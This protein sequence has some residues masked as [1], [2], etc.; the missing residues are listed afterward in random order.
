MNIYSN[1]DKVVMEDI[2][3]LRSISDS[4]LFTIAVGVVWIELFKDF[5]YFYLFPRIFYTLN[6]SV[7][8]SSEIKLFFSFNRVDK[9]FLYS[10]YLIWASSFLLEYFNLINF[11]R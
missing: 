6:I 3:N 8:K 1:F 10:L 9:R 2:G 7:R 11:D 5:I 4:L